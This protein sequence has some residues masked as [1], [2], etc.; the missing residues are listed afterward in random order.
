MIVVVH[1]S[2]WEYVG[3]HH[4]CRYALYGF[5]AA[6][7]AC[8][9]APHH[10]RHSLLPVGPTPLVAACRPRMGPVAAASNL[11]EERVRSGFRLC[12]RWA[13]RL[14]RHALEEEAGER[15][16]LGERALVFQPIL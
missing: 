8:R 3:R 9:L 2:R 16:E 6:I 10:N 7:A 12:H 1:G 13:R 14:G 11:M 15:R 5:R 4:H